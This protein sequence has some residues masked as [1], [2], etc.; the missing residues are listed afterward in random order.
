MKS[1]LKKF[2]KKSVFIMIPISC[3][4]LF[5]GCISNL[6]KEKIPDFS[7]EL[8]FK[9]PPGLFDKISSS[10]YP[11]WKNSETQNVILITSN[12]ENSQ[13]PVK[14]AHQNISESVDDSVLENYKMTGLNINKFV[15]KKITGTVDSSA[16]EIRTVAFQYHNCVFVSGLSGK[17]QSVEKDL[18]NW[19]SFLNT[20]EFKK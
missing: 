13:Y 15:S 14:Q 5:T 8:T 17:P 6:L 1:L 10:S 2:N 3:C 18:E 7:S 16:V 12:C 11:A 4:L 19:K 20:V 9:K